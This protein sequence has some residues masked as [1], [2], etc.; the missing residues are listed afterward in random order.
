MVFNVLS[1]Y[2]MQLYP[3]PI[4][5]PALN[6]AKVLAI[7][8]AEEVAGVFDVAAMHANVRPYLPSTTSDNPFD[9]TYIKFLT[10]AGVK[11]YIAYEWINPA[12]IEEV[13][14]DI[15]DIRLQPCAASQVSLLRQIL[16]EN[17]FTNIVY[18]NSS[19]PN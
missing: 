2:N 9:Y 3:A 6:N 15:V 17:G 18:I 16:I 12:T 7:V 10:D 14:A 19:T 1:T 8:S 13:T 5:A 11:T 4:I